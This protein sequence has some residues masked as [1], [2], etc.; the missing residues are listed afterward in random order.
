MA[1]SIVP[2]LD[3]A[4]WGPLSGVPSLKF[5]K[6]FPVPVIDWGWQCPLGVASCAQ[7]RT[8]VSAL[9][10]LHVGSVRHRQEPLV[11]GEKDLTHS[12]SYNP[13]VPPDIAQMLSLKS[14]ISQPSVSRADI[15]FM[16]QG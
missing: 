13:D 11:S 10:T 15:N 14:T 12:N 9:S 5:S 8:S 3:Q 2:H 6:S 4:R 1:I 7:G 16:S